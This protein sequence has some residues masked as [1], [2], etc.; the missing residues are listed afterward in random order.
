MSVSGQRGRVADSHLGGQNT[1]MKATRDGDTFTLLGRDWSGTYPMAEL[2]RW[3]AFYRDH[4]C[5][6]RH[7]PGG[8]TADSAY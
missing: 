6:P 4:D 3:L 2:P 1:A 7:G 8:D 5:Q